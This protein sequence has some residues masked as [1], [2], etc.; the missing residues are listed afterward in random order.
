M[1]TSAS[2]IGKRLE[3][4]RKKQGISLR[5][6]SEAL[7]V[8]IE[9]LMNFEQDR[10]DF[11]LPEVYMCG[12]LKLYAKY[13]KLDTKAIMNDYSQLKALPLQNSARN[14]SREIYGRM[15]LPN[16]PK[17]SQILG[18]PPPVSS[19][20]HFKVIEEDLEASFAEQQG[21]MPK[22][23]GSGS[24]SLPLPMLSN[25]K[26]KRLLCFVGGVVLSGLLIVLIALWSGGKDKQPL[27]ATAAT[28]SAQ[29]SSLTLRTQG[30]VH[31]IVRQE[32]NKER[33]FAGTLEA[34]K[35][36]TLQRQ[37]PVKIHFSDGSSLVIEKPNG[38]KIKPGRSGVGWV[39]VP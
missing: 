38:E 39:E 31:V 34:K 1:N 13:L 25:L 14:E 20:T 22:R 8:K 27:Q 6:A 24:W 10:F 18:G 35:P 7:K 5:E 33:L 11:N 37:G 32:S 16:L 17:K 2:S 26:S 23:Q 15:D 19:N 30:P 28:A 4:A 21:G 12:F 3:E 36:H 9:F 29:S